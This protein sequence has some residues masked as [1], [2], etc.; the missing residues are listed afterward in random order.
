MMNRFAISQLSFDS[1]IYS[2]ESGNA[3]LLEVIHKPNIVLSVSPN[4]QVITNY[5]MENFSQLLDIVIDLATDIRLMRCT[6]GILEKLARYFSA[7]ISENEYFYNKLQ[8]R[9]DDGTTRTDTLKVFAQ[10]IMIMIKNQNSN[11]NCNLY[12]KK[13]IIQKLFM[14]IE[15]E[16]IYDIVWNLS[17]DSNEMIS[18]FMEDL[19]ATDMYF[20]MIENEEP[21]LILLAKI[22]CIITIMVINARSN[23][24]LIF[25]IINKDERVE[26]IFNWALNA[27]DN[28]ISYWAFSL[29]IEICSK[30]DDDSYSDYC[31]EDFESQKFYEYAFS[32]LSKICKFIT[33]SSTFCSR[34]QKALELVVLFLRSSEEEPK[35]FI[36]ETAKILFDRFFELKVNS[37]FHFAF[38]D[39]FTAL[40][41]NQSWNLLVKEIDFQNRIVQQFNKRDEIKNANYWGFLY[42]I[43][44][45]IIENDSLTNSNEK[46]SEWKNFRLNQF[47]NMKNIIEKEYGGPLPRPFFSDSDFD[48]D[49]IYP[50]EVEEEDEEE[51]Y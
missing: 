11:V 44:E 32:N 50:C 25:E 38:Y 30:A 5:F 51:S 41:Q 17:N 18:S 42:K 19:N 46:N 8:E 37:N 6:Q 43:A 39:L 7:K 14:K 36:I 4:N 9:L 47:N 35:N 24:C 28:E 40:M 21:D 15:I 20:R 49:Y 29:I 3:S 2:I 16:S 31:E 1:I 48:F 26:K 10:L 33:S 13:E 22:L 45:I 27:T 12:S 34:H 23:S